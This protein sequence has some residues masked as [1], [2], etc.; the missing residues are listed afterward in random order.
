[1]FP[2]NVVIPQVFHYVNSFSLTSA[3]TTRPSHCGFNLK[4]RGAVKAPQQRTT[5]LSTREQVLLLIL[6]SE[7]CCGRMNRTSRLL[8]SVLGTF[9]FVTPSLTRSRTCCA[10]PGARSRRR[11]V[12]SPLRGTG[13]LCR[14]LTELV[15]LCVESRLEVWC[16]SASRT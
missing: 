13:L 3:S 12:G 6:N 7:F 10:L 4:S 8:L 16:S 2:F 9:N 5:I 1:M 11:V 14:S 15:R